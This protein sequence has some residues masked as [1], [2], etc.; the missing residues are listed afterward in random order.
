MV[1]S[2]GA[3]VTAHVAFNFSFG[4]SPGSGCGLLFGVRPGEFLA[5]LLLYLLLEEVEESLNVASL[6]VLFK[7]GIC[8][9]GSRRGA[10]C[11]ETGTFLADVLL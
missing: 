1:Y 10:F 5:V 8:S 3:F 6:L 9:G 2:A 11:G 4:S 7:A